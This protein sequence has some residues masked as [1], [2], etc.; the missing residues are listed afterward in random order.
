MDSIEC[1]DS[2]GSGPHGNHGFPRPLR[3]TVMLIL[4]HLRA[5]DIGRT[6]CNSMGL[7]NPWDH[8]MLGFRALRRLE[9]I[10]GFHGIHWSRK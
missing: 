8:A 5:L 6:P 7:R 10:G 3:G 9:K 4:G 1:A 2:L